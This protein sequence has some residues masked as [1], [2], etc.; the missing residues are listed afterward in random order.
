MGNRF[1]EEQKL[2]EEWLDDV[3]RGFAVSIEIA[4]AVVSLSRLVKGYGETHRRGL[5]NYRVIRDEKVATA[6]DGTIEAKIASRSIQDAI[7]AALAD[8]EGKVLR[9]QLLSSSKE[10]VEVPAVPS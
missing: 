10:S 8:P 9:G 1:H 5:Q 6:L 2:I 7:E 4:E 3:R